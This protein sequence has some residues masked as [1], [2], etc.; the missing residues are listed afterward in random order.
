[1]K[2][3]DTI[4]EEIHKVRDAHAQR[5]NYDMWAIYKDLKAK[6]IKSKWKKVSHSKSHLSQ[7]T[8]DKV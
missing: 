8:I 1:M 4:I 5:F 6:E 7:N 2:Y 3:E